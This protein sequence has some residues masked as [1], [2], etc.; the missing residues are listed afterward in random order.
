MECYVGLDVHSKA[1]VFVIQ[2]KCGRVIARGEMPT[3][4]AGFQRWQEAQRLGAGTPVALESGTVAFFVARELTALGLAPSVIDAHEVRLKAHR[5][6]QK[7]DRRDAFELCDGLRRGIYRAIVH[8]PPRPVVRLRETLSRRRHFVRL[9]TAQVNAVKRLL[10]GA[11]LGHLSRS[12]GTEVGWAKLLAAL[13]G[14]DELRGYVAEHHAVR[15]CART[16]RGG[17]ETVLIEQLA[18]PPFA[19]AL[20]RLTRGW[21]DR[22][23][24]HRGGVRGRGV[25]CGRET[26]RELCGAGAVHLSLRGARGVR[27]HHEAGVRGVAH[28]A[29]R[30][31]P[32][33]QSPDSSAPSVLRHS[34]CETRL[35]DGD[36]RGPPPPGPD[37][38][39]DAARRHGLRRRQTQHRGGPL[40]AHDHPA[41][42][43]EAGGRGA[44][45]RNGRHRRRPLRTALKREHVTPVCPVSPELR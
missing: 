10:R 45:S 26:R 29:V 30:G 37:H 1:S 22:G 16:Q 12:L 27:A 44:A 19:P 13:A 9:E 41:L 7:S 4:P 39:R 21:A 36:H 43:A 40:R 15:V 33:C 8:V 2:E 34:V 6:T 3:T 35:Q 31:R 20:R 32:P 25:V 18:A 17:L 28:H 5:P 11:G 23:R 24:D 42:P 38:V 14:Y